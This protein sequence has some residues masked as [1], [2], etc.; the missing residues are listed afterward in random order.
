MDFVTHLP[1][2]EAGYNS[3]T[4]FLDRFSNRVHFIPS[5]GTDS[6]TDV[7]DCFFENIFRLHGLPYSIVS[8]RDP[9]LTSKSCLQLMG[10]HGEE[11]IVVS[12]LL[13]HRRRGLG[14]EFLT[15]IEIVPLHEAQWK[16]LGDF[17]DTDNTITT[18]FHDYITLVGILPHIQ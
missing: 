4:T 18:A 15:E 2:T 7:A 8:D 14:Y 6:A 13:S 9:K 17:V 3:I 1:T 10:W 5:K 16:P 11:V 12:L